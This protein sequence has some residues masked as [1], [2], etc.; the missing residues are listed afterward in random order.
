MQHKKFEDKIKSEIQPCYVMKPQQW[1][2]KIQITME[3][4][5]FILHVC[6]Q[7]ITINNI[8]SLLQKL[9]ICNVEYVL[10]IIMATHL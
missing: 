10:M 8:T 1:V 7:N 4:V 2:T 3:Y 6:L 5:W 9:Q